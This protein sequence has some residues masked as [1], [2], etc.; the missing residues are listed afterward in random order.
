MTFVGGFTDTPLYE[1]FIVK[2]CRGHVSITVG[3]LIVDNLSLISDHAG[4]KRPFPALV[5]DKSTTPPP[6]ALLGLAARSRFMIRWIFTAAEFR[7][8][9]ATREDLRDSWPFLHYIR[10]AQFIPSTLLRAPRLSASMISCRARADAS[11]HDYR[12][13]D[14]SCLR[15][16]R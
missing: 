13:H 10:S 7:D 15:P 1:M 12:R 16:G 4:A 3:D 9:K 8:V 11:P 5:L 6:I 2:E 14:D